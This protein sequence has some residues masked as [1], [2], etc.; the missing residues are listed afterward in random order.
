M[1]Q[2][3]PDLLRDKHPRPAWGDFVFSEEVRARRRDLV[4]TQQELA[5]RAQISVRSIRKIE[6]GDIIHPRPSTL[7]Q[8]AEALE[9]SGNERSRFWRLAQNSVR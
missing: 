4:L 2:T 6:A 7:R 3:R 1:R 8:L 9:L 5:N